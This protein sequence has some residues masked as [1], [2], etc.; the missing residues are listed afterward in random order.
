[1][2][3]RVQLP[4]WWNTYLLYSSDIM[5]ETNEGEAENIALLI[6]V[7]C[8]CFNRRWVRNSYLRPTEVASFSSRDFSQSNKHDTSHSG[9][10][11]RLK[12]FT[13]YFYE[14]L[15][16]KI[17]FPWKFIKTWAFP[18]LLPL[19]QS[20]DTQIIFSINTFTCFKYYTVWNQFL[21]NAF[22]IFN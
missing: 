21:N 22:I 17:S 13:F 15:L 4:L 1:M 14:P 8:R 12:I 20:T 7:R 6:F 19:L 2:A 16:F 11:Y 10:L 18:C 3:V 5:W 9:M